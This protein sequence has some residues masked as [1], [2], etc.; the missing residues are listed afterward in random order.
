MARDAEPIRKYL[1]D[2]RD[3]VRL[4]DLRRAAESYYAT[5]HVVMASYMH[6][7]PVGARDFDGTIR[8]GEFGYP[9]EWGRAYLSER[10]YLSDPLARRAASFTRPYFWSEI[11]RL[12]DLT[13]AEHAYLAA[14][15]EARLGEGIGVPVF[16]PFNRNGYCALG[17]GYGN[18]APDDDEILELQVAC[19]VGHLAYCALLQRALP[20]KTSLSTREKQ[21]LHWIARGQTNAQ[22]AEG[23]HISRNTVETYIR[24][25]FEKLD[26]ND[27]VS[28][29]LRGMALGM[30]D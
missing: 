9:E 28:A 22:I 30:V 16:G 12:P 2:C 8:I 7:P 24:R 18:P 21:I 19:Q 15:A 25:C 3:A 4:D 17:F 23:L 1:R 27:R 29:A 10:L 26:V 14:A 13:E 11:P 5:T 20:A 6:Y